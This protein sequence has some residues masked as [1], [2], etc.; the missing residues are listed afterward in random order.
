MRELSDDQE[1]RGGV[2]GADARL[3]PEH[4]EHGGDSAESEPAAHRGP[5]SLL[6]GRADGGDPEAQGVEECE[7]RGVA[8]WERR[9][10]LTSRHA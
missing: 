8:K 3:E 1:G 6:H 4:A 9:R 2:G 5:H 10:R 7:R